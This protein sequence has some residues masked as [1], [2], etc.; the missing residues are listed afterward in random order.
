MRFGLVN[1]SPKTGLSNSE[2]LLEALSRR[3]GAPHESCRFKPGRREFS[4][5]KCHDLAACD[6]IVFVFPLYFDAL[7]A[8]ILT[9]LIKL[10]SCFTAKDKPPVYAII[11]NGLYEGR[12]THIAFDILQNWCERA[13]VL[14]GGGVG[15]GAG[16]LIGRVRFIP[17]GKGPFQQMGQALDTLAEAIQS[18]QLS[19][20]IYLNPAFPRF[21][22]GFCAD[23]FFWHPLARKNSLSKGDLM[24]K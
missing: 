12:Q 4:L 11:N 18:R 23:V 6:A 2:I 19:E 8:H 1:G 17:I 24:K 9:L 16:E 3:L 20:I 5:E 7:P 14:F 10:E 22:F 15:I 21:L 13:G